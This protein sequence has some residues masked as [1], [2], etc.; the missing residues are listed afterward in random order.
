MSKPQVVID[1]NVLV[2][3]LDERDSLHAIAAKL[4]KA[5]QETDTQLIFLDVVL[6][7]ALSVLARRLEE[8]KR[9]QHFAALA[10]RLKMLVPPAEITWLSPHTERYF[11][12]C[13]EV[14][15]E[16]EG[17]LNFNDALIALFCRET[18]VTQVASF[19]ADF[20]AVEWVQRLA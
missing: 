6:S 5:L 3:W 20:D 11:D 15:I 9:P 12:D 1:T 17:W 4:Q 7:E 14:M 8:R 13:L 16:S 10:H 2:A 18:G 19:D